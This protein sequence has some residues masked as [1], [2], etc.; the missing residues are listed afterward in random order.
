MSEAV[1]A[2]RILVIEDDSAVADAIQLALAHSRTCPFDV[3]WVRRLSDGL[4]RLRGE[5]IAAIL[6]NLSLPDS[7]GIET[8]DKLHRV[9]PGIPILVLCGGNDEAL[10]ARSNATPPRTCYP[11]KGNAHR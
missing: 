1:Q 10:A 6:L 11:W 3:E 2:P 9:S 5:G 8:F 4:A 7:R